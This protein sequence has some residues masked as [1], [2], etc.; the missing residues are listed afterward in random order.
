MARK[1]L[2]LGI[3]LGTSLLKVQAIDATG[4]LVAEANVALDLVI[5]Q[6]GWAEQHPADWWSALVSACRQL[7][8]SGKVEPGLIAAVGLSGQMHGAVFLDSQGDV[9]RSCLVW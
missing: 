6:P 3:D 9:L 2:F 4:L 8:A 5:P 1:P 7:F